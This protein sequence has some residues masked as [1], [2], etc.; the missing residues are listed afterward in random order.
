MTSILTKG[1]RRINRNRKNKNL[2]PHQSKPILSLFEWASAYRRIGGNKFSLSRFKPLQ[3][4]YE[5]EHPFKVIMKPSQV[6]ASEYALNWVMHGLDVGAEYYKSG[7]NALNFGYFFPTD[8][9][10]SDFSKSRVTPFQEESRYLSNLITGYNDV[11]FKQVGRSNLYLRGTKSETGLHSIPLDGIVLDEFD[12]IPARSIELAE[13]RLRASTLRLNLRLSTP[14]FPAFGIDEAYS[15][16]DQQEYQALC[17]CK[18]WVKLDFFRDVFADDVGYETWRYF[19]PIRLNQCAFITRCPHCKSEIDRLGEG[20]WIAKAKSHLRGYHIP[21]LCFPGID[22]KLLALNA[23]KTAPESIQEFHRSDLGVPF[24]SEGS[25]VTE[26]MVKRLSHNLAG[27][28]IPLVDFESVTMGVD[29]GARFHYRIS[30]EWN[31]RRYIL[32]MSTVHSLDE[33]ERLM[34]RYKVKRVV[35]DARPE[36]RLIKEWQKKHF[37]VVYRAYYPNGMAN[38]LYK[39]DAIKLVSDFILNNGVLSGGMININRT[40]AMDYV[41]DLIANVRED[42]PFLLHENTEIKEQLKAPARVT[43]K[44]KNGIPVIRWIHTKPDDY[45]HACVYDFLAYTTLNALPKRRE[46]SQPRSYSTW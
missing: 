34:S 46:Q 26:E 37:R 31:R 39:P 9:D 23:I 40:L 30:G 1:K 12:Q 38:E 19:A 22:L 6:G 21:A 16:T 42:W 2:R 32:R 18:R 8:D 29:V 24:E 7:K 27:G 14:T 44:D 20:R 41:L 11:T 36:E 25:R 15:L 28:Q 5:D 10:I 33:V 43:I 35:I 13:K 4:I 45:Y 3:K 17:S